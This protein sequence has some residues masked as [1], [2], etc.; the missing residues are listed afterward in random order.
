MI[1]MNMLATMMLVVAQRFP[2]RNHP[3]PRR[4][5]YLAKGLEIQNRA[6]IT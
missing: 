3:A 1:I 4:F 2:Q 6:N 5:V